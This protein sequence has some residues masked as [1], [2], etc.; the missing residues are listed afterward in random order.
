MTPYNLTGGRSNGQGGPHI[1]Y[2]RLVLRSPECHDRL[3]GRK[4]AT[5]GAVAD[6]TVSG[7]H[8]YADNGEY[9]VTVQVTDDDLD[10]VETIF[11]VV[12]EN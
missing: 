6:G 5:G 3:G 2:R 7:S 4:P 10:W 12:V 1:Q 9:Q 11:N 8:V